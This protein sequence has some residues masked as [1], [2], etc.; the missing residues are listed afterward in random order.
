VFS[1]NA[2][3]K[4][5]EDVPTTLRQVTDDELDKAREQGE[6]ALVEFTD[7]R[8]PT[9]SL[10]RVAWLAGANRAE[11]LGTAIKT[12]VSDGYTWGQVAKAIGQPVSTVRSKYLYPDRNREYRE[13]QRA[14][15]QGDG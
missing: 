1:E 3:T 14:K 2:G 6:A 11:L 9:D 15:E 8:S 4:E 7:E 12:A 10:L 13:R 5:N